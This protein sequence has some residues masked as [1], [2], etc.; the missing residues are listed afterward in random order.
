MKLTEEE[1][2]RVEQ[3]QLVQAQLVQ[4]QL[5][6]AFQT[7]QLQLNLLNQLWSEILHMFGVTSNILLHHNLPTL[8]VITDNDIEN[9]QR[10]LAGSEYALQIVNEGPDG[11]MLAQLYRLR[12][13]LIIECKAVWP[14]WLMVLL[15]FLSHRLMMVSMWPIGYMGPPSLQQ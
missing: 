15:K 10:R 3:Q 9:M 2:Q 11:M 8:P 14:S 7:H 12:C 5:E 6:A 1:T 13:A 4:S